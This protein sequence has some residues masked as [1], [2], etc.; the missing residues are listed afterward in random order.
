MAE[1][2]TGTSMSLGC[3]RSDRPCVLNAL[4]SHRCGTLKKLPVS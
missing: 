2:A 4:A 3:Q 1:S